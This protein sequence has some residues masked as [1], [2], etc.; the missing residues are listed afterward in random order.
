MKRILLFILLVSNLCISQTK[1]RVSI[2]S[3]DNVMGYADYKSSVSVKYTITGITTTDD[4]IV[5]KDNKFNIQFSKKPLPVG[6]Q[7]IVF[8]TKNEKITAIDTI[9]SDEE[10]VKR[11]TRQLTGAQLN[12]EKQKTQ[13]NALEAEKDALKNTSLLYHTSIWSTNFTIP[14]VRFNFVKD[15][16]N[17]QGDI[18]LFNSIGAGIGY[19]SGRL[20]RTRDD[21]GEI[22]NEEF[23]NSF[24]AN[25]GFLFSA[26]T[27]EDNKNVFAPVFNICALD[28]QLGAG[29]ELGTRATN[30]KK[31]F[32]VFSYAIP[33]YKLFKK[34]YRIPENIG[35]PFES[36]RK[37]Q[38]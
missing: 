36:V 20:E 27:G 16:E 21:R 29:L 35:V 14:L 6:T 3:K 5:K 1:P 7:I 17:K 4:T 30:Q 33:L 23:S 18:L 32:L 38:N 19:Y 9:R 10:V 34:G 31:G 25:I 15:D 22:I 2:A 8:Y 11:I 12:Y 37:S 28:I 24:G 26:G 13:V